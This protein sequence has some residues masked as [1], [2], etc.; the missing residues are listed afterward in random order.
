MSDRFILQTEVTNIQALLSNIKGRTSLWRRYGNVGPWFRGQA[1]AGEP[2]LPG[3]FRQIYDEFQMTSMFRL[4]ALAF[5]NTPET[6]R[7]DQWLFLAQHYGLPTRLLDWTE[8]PLFACFF[9]VSQWALSPKPED[10]YKSQHMAIWMMDPIELNSQ[11]ANLPAFP[12]TWKKKPGREN[13]RLAFEAE[14][15]SKKLQ[16]LGKLSPT[17]FPLAVQASAVDRRVVVQRS[18]FTIH[19]TDQRDFEALH[20]EEGLLSGYFYKFIIPRAEAPTLL[21]ELTNMGISF[22]TIYPDFNGLAME[23][24]STFGPKPELYWINRPSTSLE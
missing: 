11:S 19:G 2:P 23:L 22:S 13:F 1:D 4:K 18:C 17:K 9:A 7:L 24:R 10:S 16:Q 8:S 20:N 14:V 21:G 12:N 3:V 5:G 6:D 15:R